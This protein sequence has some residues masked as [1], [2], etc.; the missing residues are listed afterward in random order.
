MVACAEQVQHCDVGNHE[1]VVFVCT[2][3]SRLAGHFR[4]VHEPGLA[5]EA[6]AMSVGVA[7]DSY[8]ESKDPALVVGFARHLA[9]TGTINVGLG[10]IEEALGIEIGPPTDSGG[11]EP[12]PAARFQIERGKLLRQIGEL[13]EAE[14][15]FRTALDALGGSSEQDAA[16]SAVLNELGLVRYEKGDLVEAGNLLVRSL[17][18][19][20]RLETDPLEIAVTLDNLGL[21]ESDLARRAGPFWL[22]VEGDGLVNV[23]TAEHLDQ[24]EEH[25]DRALE[26]FDAGLPGSTAD[27][28]VV[29]I[30]RADVARQRRD[31]AELDALSRRAFELAVEQ[32]VPTV[33]RWDAVA[34]RGRVL[35]DRGES[36][37]G[38]ELLLPWFEVLWPHMVPH[39][40]L[41]EGL[42]TLMY[43]GA[44][45]GDRALL[46]DVAAAIV[47][48]DDELLARQLMGGSQAEARHA[49]EAYG[50][51]VEMILGFCPPAAPAGAAASWLFE[52]VLNREG[53][54]AERQGS[55]WLQTRR[56]EGVPGELVERLR[57]ARAE[58]TRLDLD[59]TQNDAIRRARRRH[60]EAERE[61][62]RLEAEFHRAL[63]S[64]R[65]PVPHITPSDVQAGL[66]PG[67]LLLDIT[68]A[69]EP[70]GSR[71]YVMFMVGAD[72][73]VRFK[74][75]GPV[76]AIDRRLGALLDM[77]EPSQAG[78]GER[79]DWVVEV[80][81]IAPALLGPDDDTAKHL[82]IAPRGLWAR[83]PHC[84]LPDADG[85]PLIENHVVTLVPSGRWLAIR[86]PLA[87][88]PTAGPPV[89]VGDAD[90]DFRFFDQVPIFLEERA[91]RLVHAAEEAADVARMLGVTPTTQR[92]AT[93]QCLLDLRSPTILH[94]ATHGD[95]L[96]AIGSRELEMHEPRGYKL[97]SVGGIA[98]R[99]DSDELGWSP[100][101]VTPSDP[102]A[103]HRRRLEWLRKVGP[104]GPL[105]RSGLLLTGFN[106]WLAG[107]ETPPDVGTGM[108]SAGELALLDLTSTGLV[109]LSACETGVGAVDYADGSL[110]GLRTAALA[111]GAA[112][113]VSSLWKVDDAATATLMSTFYRQLISGQG[114]G[115]AM[116]AAQLAVREQNPDPYYWA[117]WVVEGDSAPLTHPTSATGG[118]QRG[119]LGEGT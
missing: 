111:A 30:N 14:V 48:T 22:S 92:D 85:R 2:E 73:P 94:I 37:A 63:G 91:E 86:R 80:G 25:F 27:Y 5:E 88:H 77:F 21:V 106:A 100:A 23:E 28:V 53:V 66:G 89:V 42:T 65:L 78:D 38:V 98:V 95:F 107:V 62:G 72:G 36:Q 109:V 60:D 52:M 32:P 71:H 40:R 50:Q 76:D 41:T 110:L 3:M 81:E 16:R 90:F 33:T 1:D 87:A 35:Q 51:R 102:R 116:R 99:E 93:R 45:L 9:S 34:L 68:T 113:C 61:V 12:A 112:C 105:S 24:A 46:D 54:L 64:D 96:D 59:G 74:H 119:E 83:I 39:K 47:A 108:L 26:L 11:G 69:I 10:L 70:D 43:A 56:A 101:G 4:E 67:T 82:V 58:M 6:L 104:V 79:S 15:A 8:V 29:L 18:I 7:L 19:A 117:G 118:S 115:R 103:V 75:L 31:A 55:A 84:L 97:R 20:D 49:F 114:T 13:D 57:E 44:S 17:D